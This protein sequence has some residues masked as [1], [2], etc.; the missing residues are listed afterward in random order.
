MVK[1]WMT[2]DRERIL[3]LTPWL[4]DQVLFLMVPYVQGQ[5]INKYGFNKVLFWIQILN[6]PME[7]MDKRLAMEV[8]GA[9]GKMVAID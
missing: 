3:N 7:N 6:V 2:D 9:V 4:F 5:D 8:S 1:F